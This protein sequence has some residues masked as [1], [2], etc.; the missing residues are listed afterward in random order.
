[1]FMLKWL[2][3]DTRN[4]ILKAGYYLDRTAYN[5]C[6]ALLLQDITKLATDEIDVVVVQAWLQNPLVYNKLKTLDLSRNLITARLPTHSPK[7]PGLCTP[8]GAI[9]II[10]CV[11]R[12]IEC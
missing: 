4:L 2:L 11:S 9:R 7:S 6:S 10:H 1:M 8:F 5:L 12:T 3:S